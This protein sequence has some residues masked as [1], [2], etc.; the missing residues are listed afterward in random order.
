MNTAIIDYRA[1]ARL[2]RERLDVPRVLG[3]LAYL[4]MGFVVIIEA[5]F[6]WAFGTD[7]GWIAVALPAAA[8]SALTWAFRDCMRREPRDRAAAH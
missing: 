8:S 3:S 4:M 5:A 1:E 7:A 6:H 2:R